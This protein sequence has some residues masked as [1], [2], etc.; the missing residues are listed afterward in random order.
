MK[1]EDM[2]AHSETPSVWAGALVK[3]AALRNASHAIRDLPAELLPELI[4]HVLLT[5]HGRGPAER[6]A[7]KIMQEV[8][9]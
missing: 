4:A 5:K 2:V 7:A 3:Q 8:S 9:K 1:P 6:I